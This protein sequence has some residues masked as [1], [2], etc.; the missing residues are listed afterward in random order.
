MKNIQEKLEEWKNWSN[1][2]VQSKQE[3]NWRAKSITEKKSSST[4][5]LI[6]ENR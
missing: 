6:L 2:Q 1:S 5:F 3:D 4:T